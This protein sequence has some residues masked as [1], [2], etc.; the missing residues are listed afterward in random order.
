MLPPATY[1]RDHASS[2]PSWLTVAASHAEIKHHSSHRQS[3]GL[4]TPVLDEEMLNSYYR[5]A[6]S[7]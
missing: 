2:R 4:P 6:L 3:P 7:F 5:S 1:K